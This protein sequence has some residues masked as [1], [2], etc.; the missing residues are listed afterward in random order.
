MVF[1]PIF[2]NFWCPVV[3][4]VIFILL[5]CSV[6]FC[7]MIN[8]VQR[9]AQIIIHVPI[10]RRKLETL[11]QLSWSFSCSFSSS[12]SYTRSCSCPGS[13]SCRGSPAP[14]LGPA[15]SLGPASAL[16]PT[17]ALAGAPS[18]S[19]AFAPASAGRLVDCL[20]RK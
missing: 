15:H 7:K 12:F 9:G 10:P 8:R 16:C 19:P 13:C 3:T 17:P 2:G 18:R 20:S 4:L 6:Y 5:L 1:W 14:A 11:P